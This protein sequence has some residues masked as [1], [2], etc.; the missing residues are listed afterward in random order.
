MNTTK[1]RTDEVRVAV[2]ETLKTKNFEPI[3]VNT[4]EEALEKIK[5]LIPPGASVM[6]G[7]SRTLE[8]IGFVDYLKS[9]EHPWK[10]LH[11]EVL[12]EKDPAKQALL[13]KHAT[14]SDFYLG[15]VSA[16]TE[17][18]ELLMGSNSGSQLA[19]IAFNSQNL[20]F[21]VGAQKIV[22]SI[23][24]GLNRIEEHVVPLEHV[25]MQQKYGIPGTYW[26]KTLIYNGERPNSSR[27]IWVIMVKT[28]LGF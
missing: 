4:K 2:A 8:Q 15:S 7:A 6:N 27:K 23:P 11:L 12:A 10:N 17:E 14:V 16:L 9:G 25:N 18:G 13:R 20:I 28:E 5:Q 26:S 19:S 3:L 24:A 1:L 21:V 22:S